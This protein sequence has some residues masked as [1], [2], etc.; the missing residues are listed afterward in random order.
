MEGYV[1]AG[2]IRMWYAES[3]AGDP[4]VLLHPG[5]AGVD[6]RAWG[7][8]IEAVASRFRVL[9]PERRGHGR[10]PDT[11]GPLS[12]ELMAQDT[13]AFLETVVGGPAHVVGCS[14]GATV[15]LLVAVQRP[16]V[17]QALAHEGTETVKSRSPADFAAFVAEDSKIWARL[18]KE[19][20]A[21]VE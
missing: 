3:G 4:V 13:I 5:G 21:K 19:S 6:A 20:G 11:D 9:T 2:G 15:A 1:E 18:A 8:N 12:F 17:K 16:E 14:D 7:P 10:T